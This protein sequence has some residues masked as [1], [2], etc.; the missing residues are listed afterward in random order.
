MKL[1]KLLAKSG[2][3]EMSWRSESIL[4]GG[5]VLGTGI[6]SADFHMDGK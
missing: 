2:S 4:R 5:F 3:K 1:S 6:T